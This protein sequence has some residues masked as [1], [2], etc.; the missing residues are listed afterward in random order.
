[1]LAQLE[2]ATDP[3]RLPTHPTRDLVIEYPYMT[4]SVCITP[5]VEPAAEAATPSLGRLRGWRY[6]GTVPLRVNGSSWLSDSLQ[7]T[8]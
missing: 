5:P 6:H 4:V 1:M 3:P 2:Q 7:P 8:P